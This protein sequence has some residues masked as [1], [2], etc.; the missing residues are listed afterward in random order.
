MLID[1]HCHVPDESYEKT[2]AQLISEASAEGVEKLI[3]IGTNL[4]DSKIVIKTAEEFESVFAA[5]GIYPHEEVQRPIDETIQKLRELVDSS[6]KIVGIGECGFDIATET[7]NVQTQ[8]QRPL[9][10]QRM[11]FEKQ[12]E[13]AMEKDLPLIIHNRNGDAEVLNSLKRF[14]NIT[15]TNP[16][17]V[18]HCFTS[19]WSFAKQLLDLGFYISFSAIITYPSGKPIWET[20]QKA[21]LD[22]V[23]VETDAPFLSPQ[24]L[25]NKVN[26]PK[27]VKMTAKTLADIRNIS[28]EELANATYEN[29]C[30]LFKKMAAQPTK[31]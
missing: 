16:T 11:L 24:G 17:G 25:R 19:T 12:I 5:I 14:A 30:R 27:Y 4:E 9:D 7:V 10:E 26:E 15:N 1:T 18:A 8:T 3:T 29:S 21:P 28:F 23:L 22:K 13:L 2:P 20:A 31:A 6:N